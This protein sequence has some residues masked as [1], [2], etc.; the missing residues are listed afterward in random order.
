VVMER[1]PFIEGAAHTG[2]LQHAEDLTLS[3][4]RS[5]PGTGAALCAVWQRLQQTIPS[6]PVHDH[7]ASVGS[8]LGCSYD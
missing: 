7:A 2:D 4:Y 8:T 6:Q 1:L 5:D 3:A